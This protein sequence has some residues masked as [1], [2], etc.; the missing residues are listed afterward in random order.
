MPSNCSAGTYAAS[1][2]SQL[3]SACFEGTYQGEDGATACAACEDGYKC[4]EGSVVMIPATCEQGTYLNATGAT[5]DAECLAVLSGYWAP[6]GSSEMVA[7]PASGFRCP[8]R[9]HD[10]VNDPPGS[11]PIEVEQGATTEDVVVTEIV[12]EEVAEEVGLVAQLRRLTWQPALS[13]PRR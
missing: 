8:G 10:D 3:C 4:P 9:A 5:S 1:N 11:L 2:G 7:C 6:T 13:P 12:T